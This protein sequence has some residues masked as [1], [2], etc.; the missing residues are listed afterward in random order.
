MTNSV[1]N[2]IAKIKQ[3]TDDVPASLFEILKKY[4]KHWSK[5]QQ[6]ETNDWTESVYFGGKGIKAFAFSHRKN[7][8]QQATT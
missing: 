3:S 4:D 1:K 8:W 2:A 5:C 6:Q 7:T